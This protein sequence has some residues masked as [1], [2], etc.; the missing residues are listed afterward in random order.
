MNLKGILYICV[1]ILFQKTI[2]ITYIKKSRFGDF[3]SW[4]TVEKTLEKGSYLS[5]LGQLA[6]TNKN[7]FNSDFV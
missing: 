4:S 1:S 3:V 2:N 7:S 5:Y 6:V